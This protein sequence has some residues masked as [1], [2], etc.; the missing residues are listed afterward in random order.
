MS[1]KKRRSLLI[2]LTVLAT[3]LYSCSDGTTPIPI[4]TPKA[5][6]TLFKLSYPDHEST[7]SQTPSV[8]VTSSSPMNCWPHSAEGEVVAQIAPSGYLDDMATADLNG[9]GLTD[10]L[11][12][13]ANYQT[14]ETYEISTLL[15]QG[16]G[17]FKSGASVLFSGSIPKVQHP[18][19][20]ILTDF[21][22]DGH[23]DIFVADHGQDVAPW[24][25]YQ[26][27]LVLSTPESKLVDATAN[28]PQ[29]SDFTHTATAADI[30]GDGDM[31]IY[32]GNIYGEKRIPPQI[33]LNDG[34]GHFEVAQGLLPADQTNLDLNKYTASLFVDV[35]N[36]GFPDLFLGADD[37][38]RESV[39]LLND[40]TG[41]FT[42]LLNAMP[43]KPIAPNDIAIDIKAAD[44]NADSY[45]DLFIVYTKGTPSYIG[46]YIQVLIN[47]GDGTFSD[48][49]SGWLSQSIEDGPWMRWIDLID[50][51]LDGNLDIVGHTISG[52]II[53]VFVNEGNGV[54]KLKSLGLSLVEPGPFVFLDA[55]GD[56]GWDILSSGSTSQYYYLYRNIGC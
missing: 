6:A 27:T 50:L 33:W 17:I 25:G 26:N 15:N 49:T 30:D 5:T 48:E 47:K 8:I 11:L 42:L 24:P 13:R 53:P 19:K 9:D 54:F 36:D 56:G 37:F 14:T 55:D 35:N 22:G 44:I 2:Y 34:I 40:R 7:L 20:I 43:P 21:N 51:N 18:R 10:V 29:Q 31:D 46:W 32:V 28:L 3:L 52:D 23:I 41:H 45:L 4:V 1:Q 16:M 12:T 38:T 39:V